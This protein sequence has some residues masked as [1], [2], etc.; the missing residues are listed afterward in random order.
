MTLPSLLIMRKS[1]PIQVYIQS[2][3]LTRTQDGSDLPS[4]GSNDDP[5][6]SDAGRRGNSRVV[7][8][9]AEAFG[10]RYCVYQNTVRERDQGGDGNWGI[11]HTFAGTLLNNV[12]SGL[13]VC[14]DNGQEIIACFYWESPAPGPINVVFS[15]DGN[16]WEEDT[17]GTTNLNDIGRVFS[18]RNT[19][20]WHANS[21]A[22]G[23]STLPAGKLLAY[24]LTE[25]T[26]FVA[27]NIT[28]SP[29]NSLSSE[30][31]IHKNNLFIMGNDAN[32]WYLLRLTGTSWT[33]VWR[34]TTR[35]TGGWGITMGPAMWEDPS[36]G[37]L[38]FMFQ[39]NSDY[40]GNPLANQ[41]GFEVRQIIDADTASGLTDPSLPGG[42]NANVVDLSPTVVP[43]AL[44]KGNLAS[45]PDTLHTF[46]NNVDSPG[47]TEVWIIHNDGT[48][49]TGASHTWYR[50][51]GISTVM[52]TFA[53]ATTTAVDWVPVNTNGGGGERVPAA[54]AGRP[55]FDGGVELQHGTVT[56][57]PFVV[58]DVI[59]G[60]SGT[61]RVRTVYSSSLDVEITSGEFLDTESI[62]GGTSGASATLTSDQIDL[63][64]PTEIAG[65]STKHYF[66]VNGSGT[67]IGLRIRISLEEGPPTTVATLIASTVTV[68]VGTPATVPTNTSSLIS[69]V[70]PDG[71]STIYSV[72]LDTSGMG[73][74]A[75]EGY[76][77]MI[78]PV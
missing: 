20:Y 39:T 73:L 72:E 13:A 9:V 18:W 38:C 57:G 1:T 64:T 37:D 32:I 16:T 68:E 4:A 44:A 42:S 11:V 63:Y 54:P 22:G 2:P 34:S 41:N 26:S 53:A 59:T 25:G 78:E 76:A 36:T 45:G 55:S 60:P 21:G 24:N 29:D 12:H 10:K 75:G 48:A 14:N 28:G 19:V 7:N 27:T 74:S 15:R 33:E 6:P 30:V 23:G 66:R 3:T 67:A 8:R 62:S 61:A 51:V 71:G 43:T 58:G 46:V 70:T 17:L 40:S 35:H 47:S 52:T 49:D 56:S 5:W 69:N 50:W 31:I 77:L 65:G